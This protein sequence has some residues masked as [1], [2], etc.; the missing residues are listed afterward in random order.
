MVADVARKPERAVYAFRRKGNALLPDMEFDLRALDGVADGELVRI[1]VKQFRNVARHRG[2]WAMLA[3]VVAA[4]ECA[5][6]PERL[7]DVLK[8]E[9]GVVDVVRLPNGMKVMLPGSISFEKMTEAEFIA[10]FQRAEQWL[11]ETYG[12][13][14]ERQAA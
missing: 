10:F 5:L 9:T 11:A 6:T 2:Y 3:D 7:H 14:N 13:V 4:T 1:E 12:Y 8:L